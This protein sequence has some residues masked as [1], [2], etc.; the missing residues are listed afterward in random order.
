LAWTDPAADFT[1]ALQK[2]IL[3]HGRLYVSQNFLCFYANIFGW[4]TNLVVRCADVQ[5]VRKEKTAFVVCGLVLL[6]SPHS[7][8]FPNAIQLVTETGKHLFASFVY[9]DTAFRSVFPSI[10][11]AC[12]QPQMS[13]HR[14]QKCTFTAAHE[15]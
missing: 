4:E 10:T 1:C 14:H 7:T 13:Q 6:F 8:Q 12:S 15:C 11:L 3:V 9:R 5:Q 2:E